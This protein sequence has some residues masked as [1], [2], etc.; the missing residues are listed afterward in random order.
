MI[1]EGLEESF[2]AER[3]VL[4]LIRNKLPWHVQFSKLI[5]LCTYNL[6]IT[7]YI[8]H[9][10][11]FKKRKKL[12]YVTTLFKTLCF[13]LLRSKLF[14]MAYKALHDL[15]STCLCSLSCILSPLFTMLQADWFPFCF[16]NMPSSF[17]PQDSGTYLLHCLEHS[18]PS[19]LHIWFILILQVLA[20]TLPPQRM[21]S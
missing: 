18:F 12:D 7:L 14:T 11:I 5:T 13:L 3:N 2:Q 20:L 15:V 16:S 9:I 19:S 1:G 10:S 4:Y 8:N 17:L 21:L 6:Y